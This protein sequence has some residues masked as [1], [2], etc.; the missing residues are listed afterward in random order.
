MKEQHGFSS[1]DAVL[2]ATERKNVDAEVACRLAQGLTEGG[3]GV[4][5]AGS[6]HVQV[7]VVL[8]DETGKGLNFLWPIDRSHFGGL[9]D[10]N[11]LGLDVMFVTDAVVGVTNHLDCKLAIFSL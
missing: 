9:R 7:H 11:D 2:R 5:D 10:G 8:V 1:H 4:R 3:G 6:V